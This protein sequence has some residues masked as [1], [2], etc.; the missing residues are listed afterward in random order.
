MMFIAI[1]AL[2]FINN[3]LH[4]I[5]GLANKNNIIQ[6]LLTIIFVLFGYLI[7]TISYAFWSKTYDHG[8]DCSY[9]LD[10]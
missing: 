1:G 7:L 4:I 9:F 10:Y 8:P 2:Q 6:Y 5:L 3:L